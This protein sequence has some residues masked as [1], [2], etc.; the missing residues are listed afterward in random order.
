MKEGIVCLSVPLAGWLASFVLCVRVRVC[1]SMCAACVCI[2]LTTTPPPTPMTSTKQLIDIRYADL[3]ASPAKTIEGIYQRFGLPGAC[4][5][6]VLFTYLAESARNVASSCLY[7]C[8][9][10]GLI[11]FPSGHVVHTTQTAGF[12]HVRPGLEQYEKEQ[13]RNTLFT[14]LLHQPRPLFTRVR[15]TSD[16]SNSAVPDESRRRSR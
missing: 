15:L 6:S 3:I 14:F 10:W 9:G 7:H 2:A 4:R 13:A 8:C 5:T 1:M 16:S 11:H 12:E